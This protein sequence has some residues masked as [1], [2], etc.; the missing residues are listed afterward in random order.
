MTKEVVSELERRH[1]VQEPLRTTTLNKDGGV[2]G[3]TPGPGSL[4]LD[5]MPP[6]LPVPV[7]VERPQFV[8]L[9][10]WEGVVTLVRDDAFTARLT[11]VKRRSP[12]E[13][14]EFSVG[15]LRD[16]DVSLVRPGAIF[17]WSVG[18]ITMPGAAKITASQV[19]FRRLPQ[20]TKRDL[21]RADALAGKIIQGFGNI[22]PSL[23]DEARSAG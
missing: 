16:D 1:P 6:V 21:Q 14:G 4:S 23:T 19:V 22:A 13:E 17:R 12:D 3:G 11:D 15:E 10:E 20:W 5:F 2:F 18:I 8:T 7:T 9:Q